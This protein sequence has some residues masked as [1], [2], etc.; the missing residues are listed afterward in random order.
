MWLVR[1]VF[2]SQRGAWYMFLNC[3][4]WRYSVVATLWA[5]QFSVW[6]QEIVRQNSLLWSMLLLSLLTL[7]NFSTFPFVFCYNSVPGASIF[8]AANMISFLFFMEAAGRSCI[9]AWFTRWRLMRAYT[10]LGKV[11][12][13]YFLEKSD[14]R[15]KSNYYIFSIYV[16]MHTCKELTIPP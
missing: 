10:G 15:I 12:S 9:L 3:Y 4:S 6:F 7:S 14:V 11:N 2:C 13:S 16:W 8:E 1:L 5:L